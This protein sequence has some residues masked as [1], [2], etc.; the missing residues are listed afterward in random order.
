MGGKGFERE[1]GVGR[2]E[3]LKRRAV[4]RGYCGLSGVSAADEVAT[5]VAL[6][7]YCS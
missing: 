6:R 2:V 3:G 5:K 7:C 1:A 4:Q